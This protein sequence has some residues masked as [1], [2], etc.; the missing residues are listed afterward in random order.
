LG[1]SIQIVETRPPQK[2]KTLLSKKVILSIGKQKKTLSFSLH[3]L[4]PFLQRM[5]Q[6][7]E[8]Q[9]KTYRDTALK[10][11][12]NIDKKHC[13]LYIIGRDHKEE[14]E[15]FVPQVAALSDKNK[16]HVL[17]CVVT[18]ND[19]EGSENTHVSEEE[20]ETVISKSMND[21]LDSIMSRFDQTLSKPKA[22]PPTKV[23]E[24]MEKYNKVND[25]NDDLGNDDD[26]WED[27]GVSSLTI[28]EKEKKIEEKE[29]PFNNDSAP[30]S[31]A[32]I[33]DDSEDEE[34]EEDFSDDIFKPVSGLSV[35][36][37][38]SSKEKKELVV[39]DVAEFE[40]EEEEEEEV[41]IDLLGEPES[42]VT[43]PPATQEIEG[44]EDYETM[45][46]DISKKDSDKEEEKEG[47][48]EIFE[49]N[50]DD[51]FSPV[52]S[53]GFLEEDKEY[54]PEIGDEEEEEE[55]EEFVV[56]EPIEIDTE[57]LKDT[58]HQQKEK[59]CQRRERGEY[60]MDSDDEI[61]ENDEDM[62]EN[63]IENHLSNLNT[64]MGEGKRGRRLLVSDIVAEALH[65]FTQINGHRNFFVEV[66]KG[67]V[68]KKTR[69]GDMDKPPVAEEM[70]AFVDFFGIYVQMIQNEIEKAGWDK[71]SKF[72]T[73]AT[74]LIGKSSVSGDQY[75]SAIKER[76]R[77]LIAMSCSTRVDSKSPISTTGHISERVVKRRYVKNPAVH[78]FDFIVEP[79]YDEL[80]ICDDFLIQEDQ[81]KF[82]ND[83]KWYCVVSGQP[84]QN[85][86][87]CY[88]LLRKGCK[89]YRSADRKPVNHLNSVQNPE[90][91]LLISKT[92][93]ECV[94]HL[95][96]LLH[97]LK[98]MRKPIK[99]DLEIIFSKEVPDEKTID[100]S[101]RNA[102]QMIQTIC[103]QE[104][105]NAKHLLSCLLLEPVVQNIMIYH[106][107][108]CKILPYEILVMFGVVPDHTVNY[109]FD[110]LEKFYQID[111]D[112][113]Y[114]GDPLNPF[115][116][117]KEKEGII[118]TIIEKVVANSK[119]VGKTIDPDEI[120]FDEDRIADRVAKM[121]ET[122][123][124]KATKK[125]LEHFT[126]VMPIVP[127]GDMVYRPITIESLEADTFATKAPHIGNPSNCLFDSTEKIRKALLKC[128]LIEQPF[129]CGEIVKN[130]YPPKKKKTTAPTPTPSPVDS[131][132]PET[133]PVRSG[134]TLIQAEDEP[135]VVIAR[136]EVSSDTNAPTYHNTQPREEL[137]D[138]TPK[139][140]TTID[141]ENQVQAKDM[142]EL[143][144]ILQKN[145]Q[146]KFC[147]EIGL[148]TPVG[149]Y[150]FYKGNME[151][152]N[153]ALRLIRH[154]VLNLNGETGLPLGFTKKQ[155]KEVIE[156]FSAG[157]SRGL[158]VIFD[159]IE[160]RLAFTGENEEDEYKTKKLVVNYIIGF[161]D[162]MLSEKKKEKDKQPT[163][164]NFNSVLPSDEKSV[165]I[166]NANN[167]IIPLCGS[168]DYSTTSERMIVLTKRTPNM[169]SPIRE[170]IEKFVLD[171]RKKAKKEKR[172]TLGEELGFKAF[173]QKGKASYIGEVDPVYN[174]A[175]F[176]FVLLTFSTVFPLTSTLV[177]F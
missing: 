76:T 72:Q 133:S 61:S 125:T 134:V 106:L 9:L 175:L 172:Q 127:T 19:K 85:N 27:N 128:T 36:E 54:S 173:A 18:K 20:E 78:L 32:D 90:A 5:S 124:N 116:A 96:C 6:L 37:K 153:D 140:L 64:I 92:G 103:T 17:Q 97:S 63:D 87:P 69:Q 31:I 117:K 25:N 159:C 136:V 3:F 24:I 118:N 163:F 35:K 139:T 161:W 102:R 147:L 40:S 152:T 149:E 145:D 138:A 150:S 111:L 14:E 55:E 46:V 34:E 56:N 110:E 171:E 151:V 165:E 13:Q 73:L 143:Y 59:G 112:S 10:Q 41:E 115:D 60:S 15:L 129:P 67:K 101:L 51:D 84:I 43:T 79:E 11:A 99:Q 71:L 104:R 28:P 39:V 45:I 29:V 2:K 68:S 80:V 176:P 38:P 164:D 166:F 93:Y 42:F 157:Y 23:D 109:S 100:I 167:K 91:G 126:E 89:P 30:R 122:A 49:N 177:P 174:M 148:S 74:K 119:R 154:V 16:N 146:D 50:T 123:Y 57:C 75:F 22:S 48:N 107:S 70:K 58:L 12:P 135:E 144:E 108:Y 98:D 62:L 81:E 121:E 142:T 66:P 168:I 131:A 86:E 44:S 33:Q 95:L 162:A 4:P 83:P 1:I 158:D 132:P 65:E 52:N 94:T 170:A 47:P 105:F 155:V 160:K 88:Y 113:G 114:Q 120:E 137:E 8:E 169:N 130:E 82:S 156:G 26:F 53:F 7:Q 141:L 77:S 21:P